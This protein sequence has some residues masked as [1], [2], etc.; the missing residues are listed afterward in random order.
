MDFRYFVSNKLGFIQRHYSIATQPFLTRKQQIEDGEPP[1]DSDP[2][3]EPE[4][5]EPPFLKEWIEADESINIVG[6]TCL[7]MVQSVLL[8]YLR[9]KFSE[10]GYRLPPGNGGILVRYRDFFLDELGI[11]WSAGPVPFE[12]LEDVSLARNSIQHETTTASRYASQTKDYSHRF[13]CSLFGDPWGLKRVMVTQE[14]LTAAISAV[15]EFCDFL[16]AR[17]A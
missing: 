14:G 15:K 8:E 16:D 2:N 10:R 13:P 5:D 3:A 1:F 4:S 9:E 12:V 6:Y 7:C 17:L 11:D